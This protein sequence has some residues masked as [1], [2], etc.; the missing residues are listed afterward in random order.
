MFKLRLG[1]VSM[2]SELGGLLGWGIIILYSL[3]LLNYLFKII[4]KKFGVYIR[5]NEKVKEIYQWVMKFVIKYHT[6][7]GS[8]TLL[9]LVA[10]FSIQFATKG[11]LITGVLA[12]LFMIVEV[13]NGIVGAAKKWKTHKIWLLSHRMMA[14]LLG[15]AVISHLVLK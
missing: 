3:A 13:V 5:K 7:I 14:V 15:I 2:L 10:H 1:G 4:N 8:L 12:A 6:K 9:F 11:L